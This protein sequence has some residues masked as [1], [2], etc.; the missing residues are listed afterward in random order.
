MG[1]GGRGAAGGGA[2]AL[3][4]DA[5]NGR[6]KKTTKK[7]LLNRRNPKS[8]PPKKQNKTQNKQNQQLEVYAPWC[9]HCK[10]LAPIYAKL[11][12]RFAKVES[13]VVAK[14][15]GTE[16]EHP[17]VV[18]HFTEIIITILGSTSHR[19]ARRTSRI[20]AATCVAHD[21]KRRS[22]RQ[23]A[24]VAARRAITLTTTKTTNKNKL[25]TTT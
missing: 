25:G 11:A 13:V 15:D 6:G 7:I 22:T 21:A 17:E 12:K 10:Q 24:F 14:M 2:C 5:E 18:S 20:V 16:N 1:G 4:Q 3:A 8:S 23:R 9:G 19:M